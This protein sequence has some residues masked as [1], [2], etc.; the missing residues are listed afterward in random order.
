[1][2]NAPFKQKDKQEVLGKKMVIVCW[3][4]YIGLYMQIMQISIE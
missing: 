1:M 2:T 3:S 4:V